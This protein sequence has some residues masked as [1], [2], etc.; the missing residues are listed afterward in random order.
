M[1][2]LVVPPTST[3]VKQRQD[4]LITPFEEITKQEFPI[5]GGI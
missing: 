4:V 5:R 1:T 3:N 2:T